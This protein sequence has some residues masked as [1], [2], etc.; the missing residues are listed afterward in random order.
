MEVPLFGSVAMFVVK[1]A[2][3]TL[4]FVGLDKYSCPKYLSTS[5]NIHADTVIDAWVMLKT[6]QLSY[7]WFQ[8]KGSMR[9]P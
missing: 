8:F 4:S 7:I 9:Y 2:T 1:S 3:Q 5:L 6:M